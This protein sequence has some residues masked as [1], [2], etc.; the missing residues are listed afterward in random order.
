MVRHQRGVCGR[1]CPTC[2]ASFASLHKLKAHAARCDGV[3]K[4]A[5]KAVR[6]KF[7]KCHACGRKFASCAGLGMHAK[8]CEAKASKGTP[9]PYKCRYC[10]VTFTSHGNM[11]R[12]INH[13]HTKK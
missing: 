10:K 11:W 13:V 8:V 12:H 6:T 9:R 5:R 7:V 1:R 4:A 3:W 2:K